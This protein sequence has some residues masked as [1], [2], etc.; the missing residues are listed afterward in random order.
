MARWIRLRLAGNGRTRV[1]ARLRGSGAASGAIRVGQSGA[2]GGG[3][4]RYGG[5]QSL[6]KEVAKREAMVADSA[7]RGDVG[8]RGGNGGR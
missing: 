3:S 2:R 8:G 7:V 5:E 1:S 6:T 4:D